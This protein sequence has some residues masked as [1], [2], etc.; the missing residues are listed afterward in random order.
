MLHG[1]LD[2]RSDP[3]NSLE[4]GRRAASADKTVRVVEGAQHQLLQDVPAIRAAATAQV[5]SWVL[6]RAAGGSGGSGGGG[7]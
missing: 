2:S 6:A 3:A 4:L 1:E 7:G 5:V